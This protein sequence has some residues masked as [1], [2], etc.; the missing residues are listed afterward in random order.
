MPSGS[1]AVAASMYFCTL[2][3]ENCG[4]IG[5]PTMRRAPVRAISRIASAM[6]GRQLRMP[7]TTGMSSPS[8]ASCARSASPCWSVMSV[9]GESAADRFPVVGHFFDQLG[10]RLAASADQA[11]V[12]GHLVDGLGRAVSHQQHRRAWRSV[13][14]ARACSG[15]RAARAPARDRPASTEECRGRD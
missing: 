15:A 4:A 13:R 10:G 8:A 12:V 5:M 7:T 1:A 6:N 11:K 3:V 9:S 14:H 2:S